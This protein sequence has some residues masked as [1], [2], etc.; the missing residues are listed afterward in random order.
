[1]FTFLS[2]RFFDSSMKSLVA[3]FTRRVSGNDHFY[4]CATSVHGLVEAQRHQDFQHILNNA[5]F[6]VPDGMPIVWFG[7]KMKKQKVERIYGPKLMEKICGVAEK[8]R[9]NIFLY[10][11]TTHTLALLSDK[12]KT[13][14]PNLN[15]VGAYSPPF[16][17]L[18]EKEKR[19]VYH[20]INSSGARIVFIGLSTPKQERWMHDAR[21]HLRANALIGV[22]AAF[23]FIAGTK[24]QAPLWMQQGGFE[25]LFR[26]LQ[27]PK[28]LWKRYLVNTMYFITIFFRTIF[29][30]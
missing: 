10:G 15:I 17:M 20:M 25:W 21:T 29:K 6:N 5:G 22:G 28:R 12:L 11:T 14:F 18:K 9:W 30:R 8:K 19:D 27:E 26:L 7:K 24:A 1:M 4:I 3:A 2:V 16:S 23:D 13:Q